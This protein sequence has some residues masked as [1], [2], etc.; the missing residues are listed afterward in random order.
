VPTDSQHEVEQLDLLEMDATRSLLDQLLADS[1]LYKHGRDYLDLLK[2]MAR[3]RNFAPFNALLLQIQK[4]GMLFAASARDWRER[5]GGEVKEDARPLLILWPFAPV[6][7]VYDAEDVEGGNIPED[8]HSFV[9][10]G[11][12]S[13]EQISKFIKLMDKKGIEC[14]LFDG[15]SGRAGSIQCSKASADPK[16]PGSYKLKLNKNHAAS[17]QLVTIAHELAHLFLGHLGP[18]K[19]LRIPE[20][21]APEHDQ[22][23]IEAESIAFLVA[24]RNG[25]GSKSEAYLADLVKEHQELPRLDTYQIARASGQVEALLELGAHT[26]FDMPEKTYPR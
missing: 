1:R 7:L 4:P 20:R 25:V 10:K 24:A 17:V 16:V 3:M 13:D 19:Y 22:R 2:F 23:E 18:D 5:F 6:A 8:A 15:G 12:V 14:T 11:A 26:L 9:A 21:R